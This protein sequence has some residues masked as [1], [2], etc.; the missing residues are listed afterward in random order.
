MESEESAVRDFHGSLKSEA[1]SEAKVEAIF[2]LPN[3][4]QGPDM[5]EGDAEDSKFSKHRKIEIPESNS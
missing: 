4:V 3:N 1:K 2:S 5:V